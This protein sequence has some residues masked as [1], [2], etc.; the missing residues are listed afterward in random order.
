MATQPAAMQGIRVQQVLE[1]LQKQPVH[2]ARGRNA[3]WNAQAGETYS[4]M[5]CRVPV[6]GACLAFCFLWMVS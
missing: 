3:P 6:P 4:V 5:G 2:S 1:A